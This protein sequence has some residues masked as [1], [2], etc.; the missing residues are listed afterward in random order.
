MQLAAGGL[1]S[2]AS[3]EEKALPLLVAAK[4]KR[5]RKQEV[6]LRLDTATSMT[7]SQFWPVNLSAKR[8]SCSLSLSV[9]FRHFVIG[10]VTHWKCICHLR[11]IFEKKLIFLLLH[12]VT[13]I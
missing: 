10:Y 4:E 7:V 3:R 1:G 11:R 2:E 8:V 12:A 5:A 13:K 9:K 6:I